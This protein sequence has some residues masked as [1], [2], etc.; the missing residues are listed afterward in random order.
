[1]R[2]LLGFQS[3][4]DFA[5][6]YRGWVDESV[7]KVMH[8]RDGAVAPGS[9]HGKCLHSWEKQFRIVRFGGLK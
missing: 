6:A 4:H 7:K 8:L 3:M 9:D 5:E 1:L 2:G